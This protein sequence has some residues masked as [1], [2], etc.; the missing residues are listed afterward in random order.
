MEKV[1]ELNLCKGLTLASSAL[2][3][4]ENAEALILATEWREFQAIDFE[5]VRK[6]MHTPIVFDGRNLFEP[7]TMKQ[8]GFTYH[9]VGRSTSI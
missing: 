1:L 6:I 8:L 9:G 7:R 5:R 4:A 2:E 3:A